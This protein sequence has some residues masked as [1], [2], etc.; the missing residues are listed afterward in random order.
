MHERVQRCT[1]AEKIHDLEVLDSLQKSS[2]YRAYRGLYTLCVCDCACWYKKSDMTSIRDRK[3]FDNLNQDLSL[4]HLVG[5]LIG[6][7]GKFMN[8]LKQSSGAK[9]YIS[10][11][12][13]TQEIQICHIQG[14]FPH[15]WWW[16]VLQSMQKP[17][18]EF[19]SVFVHPGSQQQVDDALSLIR[20][21]FKDLDLT[22]CVPL[23]CLPITSWVRTLKIISL[24]QFQWLSSLEHKNIMNVSQERL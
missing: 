6:K 17:S 8:F 10:T 11:L 23:P 14:K 18:A 1:T 7:Q 24:T 19:M 2:S 5:R 9:I 16:W 15:T 13:F 21:K 20:K 12:P 4:Q 22:N 3:T